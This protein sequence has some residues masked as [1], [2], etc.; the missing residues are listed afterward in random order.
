M[1]TKWWEIR[2]LKIVVVVFH[3]SIGTWCPDGSDLEIRAASGSDAAVCKA[4]HVLPRPC[5]PQLFYFMA[6]ALMQSKCNSPPAL[7]T[8][9]R[10]LFWCVA[11]CCLIAWSRFHFSRCHCFWMMSRADTAAWGSH[12][13]CNRKMRKLWQR[14]DTVNTT[15]GTGFF[16][17]HW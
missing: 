3:I 2:I 6:I 10:K 11:W 9:N 7:C 12:Q 4:M 13:T 16:L 1:A 15:R 8:C 14:S 5:P 17:K